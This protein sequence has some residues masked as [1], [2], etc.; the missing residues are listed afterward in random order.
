[1]HHTLQIQ[2][3]VLNIFRYCH[4]LTQMSGTSSLPA[5]ARAC[6]A[7][8][9]PALDVLWK[10]LSDPSPLAQCVPGAYHHSDANRTYSFTRALVQGEWRVLRSYA[11]RVRSILDFN[12][13]LDWESVQAFLPTTLADPLLPNLRHLHATEISIS[14]FTRMLA[15]PIPFRSLISL[16]V[17]VVGANNLEVLEL[18]IGLFAE[19]S[20]NIRELSV[21]LRQHGVRSMLHPGTRFRIQFA[22]HIC[23]WEH[24]KSVDCGDIPLEAD[25]LAHLSRMPTL[26]LLSCAP[27]ATL[28]LHDSVTPICF[29][30]LLALRL[31]SASLV[32]VSL[33]LPRV[34]LPAT[35]ALRAFIEERFSKR[36]LH[37]F[38]ASVQTCIRSVNIQE[39]R[40]KEA[41]KYD[42]RDTSVLYFEDMQ[43]YMAFSDLRRIDINISW[44][45][46]LTDNDLLQLAS[47]W[48]HLEELLIN[49]NSGWCASGITPDGL[50]K[51]LRRSGSLRKIALAIDT[52]RFTT[53]NEAKASL[54]LTLPPKLSLN[55]LDSRIDD[56]TVPS[57]ATLLACIASDSDLSLQA[58]RM[59][60][61]PDQCARW[62]DAFQRAKDALGQG[63]IPFTEIDFPR[64]RCYRFPRQLVN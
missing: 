57:M 14:T 10:E 28:T 30:N 12:H 4:P 37:S 17:S 53:F 61:D 56:D 49:E 41:K 47:A 60:A 42:Y 31:Q 52:R 40:L 1:M 45:V 59:E 11:R 15:A 26:T 48:P 22:S 3:I 64:H 23:R 58:F 39:L 44:F 24:L 25:T 8:N 9:G 5:L 7:F 19:F 63:Y 38:M 51:L 20:P 50:V 18:F 21:R 27:S 35:V 32:T 33:F 46:G 13:G 62:H 55:V 6:R 36:D 54:G 34:R 2:E 43:P 29:S 16:D